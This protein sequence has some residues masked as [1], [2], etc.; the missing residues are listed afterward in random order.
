MNCDA[1]VR[2]FIAVEVSSEIKEKIALLME[3]FRRTG[4]RAGWVHPHNVHLTLVFL[5]DI[6]IAMSEDVHKVM[7]SVVSS[8]KPFICEI[9]GLGYFGKRDRPRVVWADIKGDVQF[10][11]DIQNRLCA[12]I[13]SLGIRI[14][15]RPFV[16]HL[17]FA[18]IRS[19]QNINELVRDI[20]VHKK[21]YFG[22]FEVDNLVLFK[23][24]LGSG[25]PEYTVLQHA[26]FVTSKQAG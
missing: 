3:R 20:D 16:P 21:D 4:V 12:G 14:D 5:G 26:S 2:A 22:K 7:D 10:L 25:G 15:D 23:S 24:D 19:P 18:R 1:M 17:T 11:V 6:S 13:K 9:S 8:E